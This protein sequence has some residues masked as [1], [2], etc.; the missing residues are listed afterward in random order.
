LHSQ[1]MCTPVRA[2]RRVS[3]CV[4]SRRP[5]VSGDRRDDGQ[6]DRLRQRRRPAARI[7]RTYRSA[8]FTRTDSGFGTNWFH[9]WQRQ[10]DV[11]KS[12][13]ASAQ[14]IAYRDDGSKLTFVKDAVQWKASGGMP[15]TLLVRGCQLRFSPP[16]SNGKINSYATSTSSP[17]SGQS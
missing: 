17:A 10:L 13:G 8:P 2:M 12:S 11:A 6:R 15:S 9:N 3:D 4:R 14:V 7:K 1:R 16:E 5:G